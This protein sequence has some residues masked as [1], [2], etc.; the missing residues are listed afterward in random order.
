M[1]NRKLK[2]LDTI[3]NFKIAV[4]IRNPKSLQLRGTYRMG[5]EETSQLLVSFRDGVLSD[6]QPLL[7]QSLSLC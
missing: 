5:E 3:L 6:T 4:D 7:I 1:E 2:S